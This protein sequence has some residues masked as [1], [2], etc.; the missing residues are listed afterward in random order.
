ML[1]LWLILQFSVLSVMASICS[2]ICRCLIL[3]NSGQDY[4]CHPRASSWKNFK[5]CKVLEKHRLHF[6]YL[7]WDCSNLLL[8]T[9]PDI[10]T[11]EY[12]EGAVL[13]YQG[14]FPT[15]PRSKALMQKEKVNNELN[16]KCM[17]ECLNVMREQDGAFRE[18]VHSLNVGDILLLLV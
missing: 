16:G 12:L 14:L 10:F 7:S 1:C 8:S 17:C 15:K 18:F 11:A 2:H 3:S 5:T 6:Y 13:V 9:K 4:A